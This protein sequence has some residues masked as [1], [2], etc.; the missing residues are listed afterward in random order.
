MKSFKIVVLFFVFITI[1]I[2]VNFFFLQKINNS[3]ENGTTVT[4]SK[5]VSKNSVSNDQMKENVELSAEISKIIE[6]LYPKP[7][8][9]SFAVI[10]LNSKTPE[11]AGLNLDQFIYSASLYKVF[12]AAEILRK[13]DLGLLKLSDIFEVKYPNVVN[14]DINELPKSTIKDEGPLL[15]VGDKV[16]IDRLL[17]LMFTRSEDNAANVLIDIA[18]RDDINKYIIADNGWQ[19]SDVTRKY[20]IVPREVEKYQTLPQTVSNA[21]HMAEVF[22]KIENDKLI[23]KWVSEKLKIYMHEW[24]RAGRIGL[25][26]P[27][28]VDYYRKA[29]WLEESSGYWSHDV[30]VVI[31]QHSHYVVAL[32][33]LTY[34]A[35]PVVRFPLETLSRE[36]YKLME[37][38][39]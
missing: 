14:K 23:N 37:S 21:R 7:A 9:I 32:L 30:G 31:G 19:G 11:I 34:S 25:Y 38:K 39:S 27:E 22:Y 15:K 17:E 28:F 5:N 3:N 16:T 4:K 18:D 12:I 1:L 33:S 2:I 13:V 36:I 20:L 8:E 29:G 35:K 24:N 10:D 6:K 26:I